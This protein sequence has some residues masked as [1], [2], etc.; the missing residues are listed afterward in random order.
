MPKDFGL[1]GVHPVFSCCAARALLHWATCLPTI[2][3]SGSYTS[4][5]RIGEGWV[6][7]VDASG[8]NNLYPQACFEMVAQ[9]GDN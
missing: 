4:V 9:S 7:V 5:A 1:A 6:R 2:S 8:E 3:K